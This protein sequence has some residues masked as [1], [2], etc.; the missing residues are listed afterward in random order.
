MLVPTTD[1]WWTGQVSCDVLSLYR[2][3]WNLGLNLGISVEVHVAFM[4]Y[5]SGMTVMGLHVFQIWG[6]FSRTTSYRQLWRACWPI[7]AACYLTCILD[8]RPFGVNIWQVRFFFFG[9]GGN[10]YLFAMSCIQNSSFYITLPPRDP[11][12]KPFQVSICFEEEPAL[13]KTN[14]AA[15]NLSSQ[16]ERIVFQPSIFRGDLFVSGSTHWLPSFPTK[17]GHR[18]QSHPTICFEQ[19]L[20]RPQLLVMG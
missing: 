17:E 1:E 16:K 12:P 15:A 18:M 10:K 20:P 2:Y 19:F 7:S 9:G 11:A 6:C 13:P 5:N 14:I 8:S 4:H 3:E